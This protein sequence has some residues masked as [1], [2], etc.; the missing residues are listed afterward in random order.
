[1]K[2]TPPSPQKGNVALTIL[3]AADM[4]TDMDDAVKHVQD[5]LGVTDGGFAGL[6]FSGRPLPEG[7][8]GPGRDDWTEAWSYLTQPQRV[9]AL[10]DYY[11]AEV[12]EQARIAADA[13]KASAGI[14]ATGLVPTELRT[15]N[16]ID[17]KA[18]EKVVGEV[19]GAP[20]YH[21]LVADLGGNDRHWSND[22]VH[23]IQIEPESKWVQ[24]NHKRH[25]AEARRRGYVS[26]GWEL[27][28][29]LNE[30]GKAGRLP[31][32]DLMIEVCW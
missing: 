15:V 1:M 21:T 27:A 32:G 8:F 3:A 26:W 31:M 7:D 10:F 4:V 5:L 22:S 2:S 14:P 25:L 24:P 19:I 13:L 18:V 30:A 20:D 11:N 17:Y 6:F 29:V 23:V 16:A 12:A 28:A 9:E